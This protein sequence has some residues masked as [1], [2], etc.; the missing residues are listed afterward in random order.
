[1]ALSSASGL[2]LRTQNSPLNTSVK[3]GRI[4]PAKMANFPENSGKNGL[5]HA[6]GGG[7]WADRVA[8]S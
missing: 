1:M 7:A 3:F 6:E 5:Q 2:R 4:Q 8:I